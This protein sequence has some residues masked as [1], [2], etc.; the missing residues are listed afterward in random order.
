MR[1]GLDIQVTLKVD[2]NY[3]LLQLCFCL[4]IA[5]SPL[6]LYG[7]DEQSSSRDLTT[8][9]KSYPIAVVGALAVTSCLVL[10]G[11]LW[12]TKKGKLHDRKLNDAASKKFT[13]IEVVPQEISV[14]YIHEAVEVEINRFVPLMKLKQFQEVHR[15]ACT[16]NVFVLSSLVTENPKLVHAAG[17]FCITPLMLAAGNGHDRA[18][19]FLV[20]KGGLK[21]LWIFDRNHM[22]ALCYAAFYG[23][24]TTT[25]ILMDSIQK[26][27]GAH[28]LTD[29]FFMQNTP[30]HCA[31]Q[32]KQYA[33]ARL[34]LQA[35]VSVESTDRKGDT[36][37]HLAVREKV[38]ADMVME[39][40][41]ACNDF[42]KRTR[43]GLTAL[44]IAQGIHAFEIEQVLVGAGALTGQEVCDKDAHEK[45]E[46]KYIRWLVGQ[47]GDINVIHDDD[48]TFLDKARRNGYLE[49]EMVLLKNGAK[50]ARQM[51]EK[52]GNN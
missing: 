34:L 32:E 12:Y 19:K 23:H 49:S 26:Q 1:L 5:L 24:V 10:G 21:P 42:N 20:E 37:L 45:L 8:M 14:P 13:L 51:G 4:C 27:H 33:I 31:I 48:L 47:Y 28:A 43:Q 30:L 29:Q 46:D 7:M 38:E 36:A 2:S 35:G 41:R 44:D 11:A 50:T 22:T 18:V 40:L 6:P 3:Y 25:K 39:L 16:G 15:A 9:V 17:P 52:N